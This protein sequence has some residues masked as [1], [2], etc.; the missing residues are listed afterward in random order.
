MPTMP[1]V[2]G[3]ELPGAQ[4]ALQAAGVLVPA[5]I[6]YFGTWPI[7][8]LWQRST[9]P[10]STVLVQSPVSGATVVANA[11]VILTLAE[12]PVGVVYP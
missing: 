3:L 2:V 5:S 11:S 7:T 1:N 6:G 10:P 8:A 9:K 4:T 12:Y